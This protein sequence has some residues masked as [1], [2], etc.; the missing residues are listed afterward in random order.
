VS[1]F[2]TE[3]V[4]RPY[5]DTAHFDGRNW[6]LM[7]EL[8]F[9][10]TILGQIIVPKGFVTDFASVPRLLWNQ[11]PPFGKYAPAAVLHDYAYAEGFCTREQADHLLMEGMVDLDVDEFTRTLIFN[12]VRIGGQHAWDEDARRKAQ[13]LPHVA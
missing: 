8:I 4:V 10:S 7:Q 12:G 2:Q 13:G 6:V 9:S 3:L 11:I 5:P 1:R